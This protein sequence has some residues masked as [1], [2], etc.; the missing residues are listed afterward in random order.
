MYDWL[1]NLAQRE[2]YMGN[3][4][5]A[6]RRFWLGGR[7]RPEQDQFFIEALDPAMWAQGD[8]GNWDTCW[9]TGMPAAAAFRRTGPGRTINHIPG[10]NCLTVKSFLYKSL[11]RTRERLIAQEGPAH[12]YVARMDFAPRVY[13]MPDDYFALQQAAHEAP[14]RR[15]ILKPRN[16]ARGKDIRLLADVATVPVGNRWMVQ[17]YIDHPHTMNGHK[18]VLRL[19]VLIAGVE[20][21]RVYLYEQGFA[22]L[23]SAPYTLDDLDNLY[24]HLTNPD[25]NALNTDT[26]APVVFVDLDRYRAWLR[27]RGH[28]DKALFASIR[29]MVSLT[30]ISAREHMRHRTRES[31]GDPRG[32]YELLGLD[33]LVDAQLKPWILECNLS[34]SMEV[35]AAPADGGDVEAKVKRQMIADMVSLLGL[36]TP[37][38]EVGPSDPAERIVIEA[39]RE[40]ARAGRFRRVFPDAAAGDQLP[41]LPLPRLADIVLADAVS[42]RPVPRPRLRRRQATEIITEGRLTLYEAESGRC[43]RANPTA[44]LT[45]LHATGGLEPDAITDALRAALAEGSERTDGWTIRRDVWDSLA[46]WVHDGLL[47]REGEGAPRAAGSAPSEVV[48]SWRA[49]GLQP[50]EHHLDLQAGASMACIRSAEVPVMHRLRELFAPMAVTARDPAMDRQDISIIRASSGYGVVINGVL[51]SRTLRLAELAPWLVSLLLQRAAGL[52]QLALDGCVVSR[53]QGDPAALICAGAE[54]TDDL[55]LAL[56]AHCGHGFGGGLLLAP[57]EATVIGLPAR[58]RGAVSCPIE[59]RT[60]DARSHVYEVPETGEVRLLPA[61]L[62]GGQYDIGAVILTE[63]ATPPGQAI[64]AVAVDEFLARLLPNCFTFGGT[65]PEAEAVS[66]LAIWLSQRRLL[67]ADPSNAVAAVDKLL[68]SI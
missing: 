4:T 63:R 55:A 50:R 46:D 44:A 51:E 18:Y 65:R 43:Y 57:G 19:Y 49:R 7:R 10:N 38:G 25:I 26:P 23:A 68:S 47:L 1:R 16:A 35:C 14:D 2:W 6:V 31:G 17:E 36:N 27:D 21:L 39:E 48:H 42:G 9:F 40:Q 45:W 32:C 8:A 22:K 30:A 3:T 5:A 52:A 13:V 62:A 54:S 61:A 37:P 58:S 12:E 60:A 66:S 15:W 41:F 20:P 28:D 33:C 34:P 56:A 64:T 67:V 11:T 29:D 24:A 53:G 59:T